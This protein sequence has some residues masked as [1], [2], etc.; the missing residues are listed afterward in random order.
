MNT[1]NIIQVQPDAADPTR[2]LLSWQDASGARRR[3]RCMLGKAGVIAQEDK[4]EGDGKTP[5]GRYPLRQ[6]YYRADRLP[7]PQTQL[8][9]QPITP[10]LGWCDD[11]ERPQDYNHPVAH[12]YAGSAEHLWRADPVYDLLVTLGHNDDPPITG[13]GSAIFLHLTHPDQRPTEGCI[14][15]DQPDLLSLLKTC[16][17]GSMIAILPPR[18]IPEN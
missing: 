7:A 2:G 1:L 10:E 9:V 15:L 5:L 4:R 3:C 17:A 13:R 14:A 6:L 11:P 16:S 12:P 18:P 8:P